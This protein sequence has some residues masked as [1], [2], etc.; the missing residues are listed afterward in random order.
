MMHSMTDYSD[1]HA[2][3]LEDILEDLSAGRLTVA[4]AAEQVRRQSPQMLHRPVRPRPRGLGVVFLA[5]GVVFLGM[6]GLIGVQSYQFMTNGVK[7]QGTVTELNLKKGVPRP[8][9]EYVVEGTTYSGA[10]VVGI[11]EPELKVGDEIE[12]EYLPDR[13]AES[14]VASWGERWNGTLALGVLGGFVTLLGL[15]ILVLTARR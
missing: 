4:E 14:R 10:A 2:R 7:T 9:Y 15:F 11:K 6:A 13:P 3:Q 8:R 1:G 12:I 5:T